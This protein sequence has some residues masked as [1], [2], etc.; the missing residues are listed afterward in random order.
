VT[1]QKISSLN[2]KYLHRCCSTDV[3]AFDLKDADNF[4]KDILIGDIIIS[5]DAVIHNSRL[6]KTTYAYELVLYIAHGI[7]HLLGFDDQKKKSIKQMR[8]KEKKVMTLV[9]NYINAS[10]R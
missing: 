2:K 7:L 10:I 5:T 3:L 4:S 9:A 8:R 1:S 6:F